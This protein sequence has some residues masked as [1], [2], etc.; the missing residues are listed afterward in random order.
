MSACLMG[1]ENTME[2]LTKAM[3]N[4]ILVFLVEAEG[5]ALGNKDPMIFGDEK[6]PYLLN[7]VKSQEA[8]GNP[9]GTWTKVTRI[10]MGLV[11]SLKT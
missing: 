7:H 6:G 4:Q 5:A 9:G 8:H 11:D 3:L 1:A 2:W 10:V